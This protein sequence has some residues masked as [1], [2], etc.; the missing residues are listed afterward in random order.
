MSAPR[1]YYDLYCNVCF[2]PKY[3]KKFKLAEVKF[4][5]FFAGPPPTY[6]VSKAKRKPTDTV[7]DQLIKQAK[8][9]HRKNKDVLKKQKQLGKN[10]VKYIVCIY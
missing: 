3:V 1:E 9:L 7:E 10:L 2:Q 6:M 4:T 5:D 8:E